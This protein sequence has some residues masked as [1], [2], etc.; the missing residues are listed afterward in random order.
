MKLAYVA[1]DRVDIA[2][3]VKCLTRHMKEPRSGHMQELKRLRRYLLK[4]RRCVLTYAR[5]TSEATL[6]V[7]VGSDW[8]GDLL[9]RRSTTGLIVRRGKHL[10]THMS[11]LQTLVA[12]SIGE[13]AYYALFRGACTSLGIQS[14]Y[15]DWMIDVP[16]HIYSDS[17]AAR[18]VARRRGIGGR[19]RHLQTRHLWLQS[20]V[21]PGHL[22]L[23][24]VAG[25]HNPAD[26]LTKPLPGRKIREWSEHVG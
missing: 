14:H 25:E 8:A 16:I 19:L 23:D 21:A 17:S 1:Q 13:P 7:L 11:R 6:Q 9:E 22:K 24:V 3:A 12:L 20:R 5:Q 26:T 15:Q 4:N 18:S 10:L 2:E